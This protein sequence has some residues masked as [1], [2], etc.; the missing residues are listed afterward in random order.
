MLHQFS[1]LEEIT[2]HTGFCL[3]TKVNYHALHVAFICFLS[4]K[5]YI[6]R[7][8]PLFSLIVPIYETK[9]SKDGSMRPSPLSSK[10]SNIDAH[11]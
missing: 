7:V 8:S 4:F 1:S 5:K 2:L 11:D 6:Q 3:K 9:G 10:I